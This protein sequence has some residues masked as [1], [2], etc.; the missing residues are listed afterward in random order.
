MLLTILEVAAELGL[1]SKTIRALI[2]RGELRGVRIGHEWRV[3][4]DDLDLF[5]KRR[6]T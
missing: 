5:L 4:R 6:R 2:K 3:D 1:A